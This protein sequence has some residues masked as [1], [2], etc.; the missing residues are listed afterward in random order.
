[1]QRLRAVPHLSSF[2][3][4]LVSSHLELPTDS[5]SNSS[6]CDEPSDEEAT[7]STS[8]SGSGSMRKPVAL[9]VTAPLESGDEPSLTCRA[10]KLEPCL[11]A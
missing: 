4:L 3:L 8:P 6:S 11:N 5:S 9:L 1:M 10:A 2:E 7:Q